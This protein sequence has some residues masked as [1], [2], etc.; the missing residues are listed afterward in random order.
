MQAILIGYGDWNENSIEVVELVDFSV[1]GVK[2]YFAEWAKKVEGFEE[3]FG[4]SVEEIDIEPVQ[5]GQYLINVGECVLSEFGF[6]FLNLEEMLSLGEK[7]LKA[8]DDGFELV[9]G[10][11]VKM[12][13][14]E[15][16]WNETEYSVLVKHSGNDTYY[17]VVKQ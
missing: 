4:C 5:T 7:V 14:L 10:S 2:K 8:T 3:S 1:E 16:E 13:E 15:H 11:V 9:D 12:K 6:E 17:K